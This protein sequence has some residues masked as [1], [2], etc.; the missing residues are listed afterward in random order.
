MMQYIFLGPS[1][2]EQPFRN[3]PSTYQQD[4]TNGWNKVET[5]HSGTSWWY[6]LVIRFTYDTPDTPDQYHSLFC[7]WHKCDTDK[8]HY[9]QHAGYGVALFCYNPF[10]PSC[11][12]WEV[13]TCTWFY[14]HSFL[15]SY[16][17]QR[18]ANILA[19]QMVLHDFLATATTCLCFSLCSFE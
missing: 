9:I 1:V 7:T 4:I 6:N 8:Y 13:I 3:G 16:A 14:S 5:I 2:R 15:K 10:T 12:T 19:Y 17:Q 11:Y 18:R